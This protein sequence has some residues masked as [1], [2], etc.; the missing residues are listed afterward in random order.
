MCASELEEVLEAPLPIEI[1]SLHQE[2]DRGE[3]G[4]LY[5]VA[6]MMSYFDLYF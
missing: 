1:P 5:L 4:K 6:T 3:G 2:E